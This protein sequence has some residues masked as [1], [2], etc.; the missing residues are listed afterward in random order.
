MHTHTHSFCPSLSVSL[1]SH[2]IC[3]SVFVSVCLC[4]ALSLCVSVCTFFFLRVLRFVPSARVPL[5]PAVASTFDTPAPNQAWC[6]CVSLD[7]LLRVSPAQVVQ[8]LKDNEPDNVQGIGEWI[9]YP[10]PP[11]FL[12]FRVRLLVLPVPSSFGRQRNTLN[13]KTTRG[14]KNWRVRVVDWFMCPAGASVRVCPVCA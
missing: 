1:L 10:V 4:L 7:A 12:C 9:L 13:G 2:S 11:F 14:L 6:L 8:F 5:M 3:L